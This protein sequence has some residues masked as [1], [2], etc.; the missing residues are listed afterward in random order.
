MLNRSHQSSLK[1]ER[2]SN[3]SA[4]FFVRE[5]AGKDTG[6]MHTPGLR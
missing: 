2:M 6:H 5:R 1:H 3:N 4:T